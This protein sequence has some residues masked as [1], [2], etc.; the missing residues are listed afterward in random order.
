[1]APVG[2]YLRY[3]ET[4]DEQANRRVLAL[5]ERLEA[6]RPPGVREIYPG[7]GSVYV[8][9]DDGRLPSAAA[10]RWIDEALHAPDVE[11]GEPAT[12]EVPVR[13]GGLDTDEVAEKT[14]LSREQIAAI[15]A[16]GEYRVC[17]RATA[18]QPML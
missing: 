10:T 6:S 13:Y 17:A 1:M 9:W 5:A 16:A 14:G 3:S 2:Q 12:V 7:Y 15:H 18:G 4:F 11:H 8:E